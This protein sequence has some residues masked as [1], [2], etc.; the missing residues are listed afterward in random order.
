V[1]RAAII[2][3]CIHIGIQCRGGVWAGG[4]YNRVYAIFQRYYVI[5][6]R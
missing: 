1:L 2:G 4:R 6:V 3:L 5:S